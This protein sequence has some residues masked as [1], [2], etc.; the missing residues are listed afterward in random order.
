MHRRFKREAGPGGRLI[1]QAGKNPVLVIQRP[2]AGHNSLHQSRTGEQPH[3]QRD[4]ELLRLDDVLQIHGGMS[5]ALLQPVA[6]GLLQ[7]WH[8]AHRIAGASSSSCKCFVLCGCSASGTMCVP[9]HP[10]TASHKCSCDVMTASLPPQRRKRSTD[11]T[12]GPMFP[13]GKWP[14]RQYSSSCEAVTCVSGIWPGFL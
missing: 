8:A 5:W 4:R 10:V 3:Q 7:Y 13:G 11:S 12:F 14:A 6:A 2:A 9:A 1:K